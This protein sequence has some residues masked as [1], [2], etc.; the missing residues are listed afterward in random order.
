MC[1]SAIFN[2]TRALVISR[3]QKET[4][5]ISTQIKIIYFLQKTRLKGYE[6]KQFESILNLDFS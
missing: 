4:R 1:T 6:I 3:D 5:N 2:G